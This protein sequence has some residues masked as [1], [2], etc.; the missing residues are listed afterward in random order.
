MDAIARR[1]GRLL[2]VLVG[3]LLLTIVLLTLAQVVARYILGSA[4]TW[5]EELNLFLWI[6]MIMLAAVRA[7][8]MRID[9]LVDHLGP[10]A[11]RA[12]IVTSVAVCLFLFGVLIWGG[13][14][15]YDL[16]SRDYHIALDWL[17]VKWIFLALIVGGVLW[18]V[19]VL[20]DAVLA[21]RTSR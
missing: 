9:L 21:L 5:S 20:H 6:W 11:Q 12:V 13:T 4:L 18:A 17:S 16:T 2:D 19:R 15:L 1:S 8:H 3:G 7:A 10:W 14:Q